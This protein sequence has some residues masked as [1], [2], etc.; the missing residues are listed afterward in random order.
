MVTVKK[1]TINGRS[2]YYLEHTI[3]VDGR[4]KKEERYLGRKL[5]E[6]IESQ[7]RKFLSEIYQKRWSP[8]LEKIRKNYTQEVKSMPKT[9]REKQTH[10]FS[11]KFTYDSNRIE[12]STLTLRETADLIERGITPKGKP[13]DDVKEAEAHEKLFYE[14][15][16]YK[17]DP[18][19]QK[20]LKWHHKLLNE[21][22]KDIAG[23]IRRHPVAISGSR[24][25]PPPPVE[26][27]LQLREFFR[28]Y[29]KN[30]TRLNPVELAAL[31][32]LKFVTIHPFSDG[33]GRISRLIMNSILHKHSYPLFNIPYTNRTSYYNALERAQTKKQEHIFAHWLIKKYLKEY[34]KYLKK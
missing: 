4:I 34:K 33:N 26:V 22:K 17:K 6:D 14:M 30:K 29:E 24:Y 32:H 16:D 5:P 19:R 23:R 15:L 3:R 28:W 11:I 12:G 25:L 13:L 10:V 7:K 1:K 8:Q 9:L 18:T 27:E 20:I 31:A 21:T 2:Y